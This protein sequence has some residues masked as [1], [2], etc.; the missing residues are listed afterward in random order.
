MREVVLPCSRRVNDEISNRLEHA[1]YPQGDPRSWLRP[2]DH[3]APLRHG[4]GA[5]ETNSARRLSLEPNGYGTMPSSASSQSDASQLSSAS[6]SLMLVSIG[7]L[8]CRLMLHLTFVL[9]SKGLLVLMMMLMVMLSWVSGG[10][11]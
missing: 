1:H 8:K 7:M 10:G 3:G 2:H 4:V 11:D 6:L 9:M 5:L